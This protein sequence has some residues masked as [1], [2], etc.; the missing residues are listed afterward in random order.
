M[1][2]T[3]SNVSSITTG[4]SAVDPTTLS[5]GPPP[6]E[7]KDYTVHIAAGVGIPLG[8]IAISVTV[9]LFWRHQQ[10]KKNALQ[11]AH[12][13]VTF[14]LKFK[15]WT[16]IPSQV[17]LLGF[18]LRIPCRL[19]HRWFTNISPNGSHPQRCLRAETNQEAADDRKVVD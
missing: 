18:L 10:M 17:L 14:S 12:H 11:S 5:Q 19:T 2:A 13:P 16:I 1:P 7:E 8:I 6:S 15:T 3:T 4:S 9:F